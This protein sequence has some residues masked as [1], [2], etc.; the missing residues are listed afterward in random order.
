M[1]CLSLK[2]SISSAPNLKA[3]RPEQRLVSYLVLV[4][5]K[6]NGVRVIRHSKVGSTE[7]LNVVTL[8]AAA[9]E[10]VCPGHPSSRRDEHGRELTGQSRGSADLD[11]LLQRKTG[12]AASSKNLLRGRSVLQR[13]R[14][15]NPG[16]E[17][18]KPPVL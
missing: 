8:G 12:K 18:K 9:L 10:R 1:L 4:S 16:V 5:W 15:R 11:C 13:A 6:L 2:K 3:Y 14:R 7:L 17:R